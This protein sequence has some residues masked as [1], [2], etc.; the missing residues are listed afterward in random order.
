MT[1]ADLQ[2][3]FKSKFAPLKQEIAPTVCTAIDPASE[4][5][6]DEVFESAP[7]VPI[8]EVVPSLVGLWRKEGLKGLV[9]LEPE[10]RR[11]ADD[12]RAPDAHD[13][14]VSDFIYAMY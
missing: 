4:S 3:I 9:A 8:A 14:E 7:I 10:V 1:D 6:F 5:Y 2:K 11:M 12:L 13:Q